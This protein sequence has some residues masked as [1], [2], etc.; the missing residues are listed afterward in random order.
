MIV[1]RP[2]VKEIS[3]SLFEVLK[4]T[5][6]FQTKQGRVIVLC[7]CQNHQKF[8]NESPICFHKRLVLEHIMLKPIK[9]RVDQLING[10][11]DFKDWDFKGY[12]FWEDLHSIKDLMK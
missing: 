5:V 1:N 2:K 6:K 11:E 4:H 10:L 9:Q 8:C 7:S 12:R 3:E